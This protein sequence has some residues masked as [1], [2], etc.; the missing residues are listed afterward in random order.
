MVSVGRESNEDY[1]LGRPPENLPTLSA[2]MRQRQVDTTGVKLVFLDFNKKR[3][4][5]RFLDMPKEVY[6]SD[7][8]YI[9]P[10]RGTMLKFLDP[11]DNPAFETLTVRPCIAVK[12]H[13]PVGRLSVHIDHAYNAC[14]NTRAGFFGFFEC[15]DDQQV[16]HAMLQAGVDWLLS[17][18]VDELFGPMNFNSNH[19][20]GLLVENFDRPPFIEETYNPPYYENLL[21][22]F[23]FGKAKDL[24]VWWMDITDGLESK[25]RARVARIADRIRKR[26]GVSVR[27]LNMAK[28]EEEIEHVYRIYVEAWQ[29]NWGFVP[30]SRKEFDWVMDDLRRI[31][32][33]EM[34]LFV[35]VDGKPVG[36]SATLPNINEAMPKNGRLFPFGWWKLLTR[37]KKTKHMRLYTLGVVSQYR[38]R[39][40]ESLMFVET[41]VRARK[42]G[43]SGGEI[44]W[45]LEDNHMVN[46]AI[47]SLEGTVDRTYRIF[48]L[49]LEGHAGLR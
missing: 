16:A 44:G 9:A 33:P 45:T 40:L 43:C 35:E 39:G 18:K 17:Q 5:R 27:H 1:G 29:K 13:K 2:T 30:V 4:R 25:K 28:V 19:Q 20:I 32:I 8:N 23:G 10:L 34:V 22:S 21:T 26:E 48:G 7:P 11:G 14:H 31:V 24:L 42:K 47:E 41:I 37:L 49:K 36:F 6:A 12:D 3:D 38:K 15:I 46:R